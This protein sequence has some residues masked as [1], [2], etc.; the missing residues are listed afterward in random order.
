MW[1]PNCG[2]GGADLATN[3]SVR[4]RLAAGRLQGA[5][6]LVG[7]RSDDPVVRAAQ[8]RAIG[9]I[10]AASPYDWLPA[11]MQ[12]DEHTVRFLAEQACG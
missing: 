5:P 2:V 6:Q 3:V 9:A 11:E 8:E 10:R 4:F 1:R 7:G 12:D